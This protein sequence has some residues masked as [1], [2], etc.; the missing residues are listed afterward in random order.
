VGGGII[1]GNGPHFGLGL[2]PL[3]VLKPDLL[4]VGVEAGV[5]KGGGKTC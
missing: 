3:P 5:R 4:G 1:A 2:T